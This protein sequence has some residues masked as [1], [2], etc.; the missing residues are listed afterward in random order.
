[1]DNGLTIL[2]TGSTGFIGSVITKRLIGLGYNVL[3]TTRTKSNVDNKSIFFLDLSKPE[4]ILNL[5]VNCDVIVHLGAQIGWSDKNEQTMSISNTIAS[6]LL[7][8]LA[9]KLK[10]KLIFASAA[11]VHGIIVNKITSNSLINADTPYGKSKLMAEELIR[12][13]GAEYCILRIG[14]VFGLN[15]PEHLGINKAISN[16]IK[17][18]TPQLSGNGNGMRNYIYLWDVAEAIAYIIKNNINGVHLLAGTQKI[19]IASMLEDI[20]KEFIPG[21]NLVKSSGKNIANQLIEPSK[22][23]P[24]TRSFKSALKDIKIRMGAN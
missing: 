2:V 7:A 24:N 5:A 14:G 11:I 6:G 1:M 22:F 10:A 3:T 9:F 16:A 20:C 19:T 8:N 12:V 15:G 13:S 21:E 18:I 4:T 17:K 23:L